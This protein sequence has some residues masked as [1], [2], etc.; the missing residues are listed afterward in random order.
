ML[1]VTG[2]LAGPSGGLRAIVVQCDCQRPEHRVAPYTWRDG[3]STRCNACAKEHAKNTRQKKFLHYAAACPDVEH[4]RRLLNRISALRNRCHNPNDGAYAGYGARG[5]RCWW[6]DEYGEATVG[7][8]S[9][10]GRGL[11][12]LKWKFEMLRYLVTL[13]GW[14]V[15]ALELDRIDNDTGYAPGNLRFISHAQNT[16]NKRNVNRLS[17]RV[18]ELEAEVAR[19][20]S[21]ERGASGEVHCHHCGRAV[22]RA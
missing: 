15:P 11:R 21:G 4:R 18:R 14:D 19:L 5:L 1:T 10:G 17:L 16:G 8:A 6:Y 20:R 9:R 2:Y 3:R 13:P 7:G 12:T 22:D